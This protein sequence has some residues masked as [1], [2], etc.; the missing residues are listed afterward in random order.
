MTS[1]NRRK[2]PRFSAT[3]FLNTPVIL[4]PLPPFFGSVIKGKLIDLSAS[5]L[6]LLIKEVIPVGTNLFLT[7]RFPDLTVMGCSILVRRMMPRDNGYLHGIEFLDLSSE[8]KERIN[9][10]SH[11]YIDCE[12]RI[13]SKTLD[14]CTRYCSFYSMC[15]KSHKKEQSLDPIVHLEMIFNTLEKIVL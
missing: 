3:A 10:M 13:Q 6:S 12:S 9:K 2:H 15:L 11:D 14:V 8:M 5:G 4:S 1:P 7:L